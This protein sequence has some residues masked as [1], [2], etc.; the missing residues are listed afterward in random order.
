MARSTR[1][2]GR[3]PASTRG[4]RRFFDYPRSRVTGFRRWLPSWR[5]VV[6]TMLAGVA[7]VTGVLVAAWFTTDV[8]DELPSVDSQTST[9]YWQDGETTMGTYAVENREIIDFGTLPDYVGNAVVASEDRS[10]WTNSGIDVKGIARAFYNNLRGGDLQGASTITQQY[11]ER[12]YTNTVTDYA[13]KA[14]EAI[15]ALKITQQQEKPEI[16]GNY[17][18]TIYFGRGAYGIEAAADKY[19]GKPAAELTLSESAMIAGIIPNPTNWDPANN[20][21][22]AEIRWD[23]T[24]DLLLEDGH[25][26]AADHQAALDA[27]FPETVEY[28]RSDKYGGPT[29]Y[30]LT[31]VEQ[32]LE[33]NGITF[34]ALQSKGYQ[35]TTTVD[36]AMQEAAV[37]A[38]NSIPRTEEDDPN[39]A[40][41][42][43]RAAIV[44]MD[45]ADGSIRALYGG[46]DAV[47]QS[48]NNATMGAAQG[49][50][51][52][53]PFTL[54]AALEEG[55]TLEERF[56]GNSPKTF[57]EANDG[58]DWPVQN[59]GAGSGVSWGNIDLTTATA[60]S[61]N[62]VYAELNIE[63]GPEKT[64]EVAHRA[65][66]DEDTVVDDNAANVL[67]T[68][69]VT[70]LE[71]TNAYATF[72]A[73]GMRSTP[74]IVASVTDARGNLV[75]EGPGAGKRTKQ[76]E[77]DVMAAATYAMTQVVEE[78]SGEPAQALERPVAGKTGTSNA[79]RSAWFAGYAP[80]LATVVGLYQS[81]PD[82]EQEQITPFGQWAGSSITGGTWPVEAWTSYMQAALADTPVEEFPEYT[83]PKPVVPTETPTEAPT[84]EPAEEEP[85]EEPEPEQP[86]N[87]TVPADLVGRTVDDAR[88]AL[89]TLG[90]RAQVTEEWSNEPRGIVI[91][92]G[93]GGAAVPPGSTISLVVSKGPDP[94][95]QPTEEPTEE[96]TGEPTGEPTEDPGDGDDGGSGGSGG[97]NG[98]G[99]GG[100]G[101]G[102]G[103]GGGG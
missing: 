42:N 6:G 16:L 89:Q 64:A 85:T 76:F 25:I 58:Q 44:S 84:E 73:Q 91:S 103:G 50:S 95:T 21:E 19:Y 56:D 74:H 61:V 69:T 88:A 90:L 80:Q 59:F 102:S 65:G 70:P 43:L 77:P 71:L 97:G 13:G 24:L 55:R 15:L 4:R 35:V 18:N 93:S 98:G 94:A 66:I 11:V 26:S 23:R 68:A 7:L 81:G 20:P 49:G 9:V 52:F 3:A 78:G 17:L 36:P 45:P 1:T 54:V 46:T 67:G 101:G 86:E 41:E 32:E 47:S 12:Y 30:L 87:V 48:Y 53:K 92:A 39:P 22:Q 29:G 14:R 31:M 83:P 51:T 38:A 75:Y 10:F 79:N 63:T 33:E 57:P 60:N 34:D 96:P 5:V 40:S 27:G 72:A 28:V 37:A 99:N 62:T 100:G 2:K 8:P 82:G